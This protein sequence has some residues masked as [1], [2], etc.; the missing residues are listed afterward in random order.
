MFHYFIHLKR[1]F[2][3]SNGYFIALLHRI[4]LQFDR[5]QS[6]HRHLNSRLY[7]FSCSLRLFI[8]R[9]ESYLKEKANLLDW[10][11]GLMKVSFNYTQYDVQ[12]VDF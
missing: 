6:L 10:L 9:Q 7:I 8:N 2:I 3:P 12:T 11:Q 5:H 1:L 4:L